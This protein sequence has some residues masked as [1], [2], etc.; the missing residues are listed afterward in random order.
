MLAGGLGGL[1]RSIAN[2]MVSR[3]ARHLIFL[4][5]SGDS[6]EEAQKLLRE[7]E[8]RGCRTS[9]F[10]CDISN[11]ERLEQVMT[12]CASTVPPIRGCIQGAMQLKDSAFETMS[13]ADFTAAI[14]PK[15]HGSWNLHTHL[16]PGLDFFIMLSSICGLIGNRGQSNYAAGNT[17]QDSLAHFRRANGMAASTID[18]GSMLSV[19]FIAEHAETVNPYALAAETIR[20][21][22]FH[23]MLEYH[24]DPPNGAAPAQVAVG[25]TTKA[26]F[27]KKGIPEPSFLHH[28]LFALM[29][30]AASGF[31]YEDDEDESLAVLR[32][33]LH[34]AKSAEEAATLVVEMLVKRLASVMTLP[35]EDIDPG[36]PVH[37]YG[38]DSLVAVEFRNWLSKNLEAEIEVLDIMGDGSIMQLSEKIINSSKMFAF[39][40]SSSE[41]S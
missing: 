31:D 16:P 6:A 2:W 8:G 10:A 38:V 26:A 11:A 34:A 15:V 17:Y 29:Q 13:H 1:G 20:E 18:L 23:A 14:R 4:S 19:G 12:E 28:P 35:A 22:E 9:V 41:Q 36:K 3:G 25:L 32:L 27:A 30:S 5:R 40:E 24:I 33:A 7:L 21:D 39:G 37:Y